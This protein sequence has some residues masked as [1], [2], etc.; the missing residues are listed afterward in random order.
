M[1][2]VHDTFT[3]NP[4]TGRVH[5]QVVV[6]PIGGERILY[7]RIA[8]PSSKSNRPQI[9]NNRAGKQVGLDPTEDATHL[10]DLRDATTLPKINKFQLSHSYTKMKG[11]ASIPPNRTRTKRI[12]QIEEAQCVHSATYEEVDK[13]AP[14]VV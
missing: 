4:G 14:G 9:N 7:S 12:L 10:P 1:A 3:F 8:I 2:P 13:L 6:V 5:L 11:W